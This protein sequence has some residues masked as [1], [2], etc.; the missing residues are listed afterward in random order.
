MIVSNNPIEKTRIAWVDTAK[1]ICIIAVIAEHAACM[2]K[3]TDTI[4]APFYLNGF[5]FLAGY[6]Y[7]HEEGFSRFTLKKIRQLSKLL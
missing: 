1:F 7:R 5:F 2:T 4:N 6:V 3:I